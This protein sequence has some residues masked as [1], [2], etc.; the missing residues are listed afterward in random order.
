ML[1]PFNDKQYAPCGPFSGD[2]GRGS[3]EFLNTGWITVEFE[4]SVSHAGS[5]FRIA[6]LDSSEKPRLVLLDHI[7]H[8]DA[9]RPVPYV[10]KSYVSYKISIYIPDV[11]CVKCTLQLLYIMTDKSIKCGIDTCYY[12][13]FDAACKGS[14]DPNKATCFGAPN[15]NVCVRDNECFSNCKF[16]VHECFIFFYCFA[17][18]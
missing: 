1:E 12:N 17:Y 14:T 5:P 16:S 3:V 11:D 15:N 9:S 2:W 6:L 13:E 4:E 7:P 18:I 8:N 10:E